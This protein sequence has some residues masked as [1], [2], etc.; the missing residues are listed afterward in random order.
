M[1]E[2]AHAYVTEP[3]SYSEARALADEL[4]VSA[5]LAVTLVRRGYR[6]VEDAR[7]FLEADEFHD[8]SQF[9]GMEDVVETLLAAAESRKRITVHGDYDVDGVCSTTILVSTLREL[10]ADCDWYI[11]DRL[12]EGYGV[13]VAGVRK[14]AERGTNLLLTADCGITSATEVREARAAGLE[15]I[16]T[17]HHAPS[18]DVPDCPVLHPVLSDY[19]FADLC[20][21]GVAYKLAC[22][23]RAAA[24]SGGGEADD[25]DLDLV[26][27][28]TVADVVPLVGENRC[29]VRRGLAVARR[30]ARPGMRALIEASGSDA[31]R[32][33]EGDL[34]FRLAP[35]IN[36]AGRL[37]RADAGVE[38]FLTEDS[39]RAAEIAVELDR[40]NRERRLAEREVEG[41]AEAARRELPTELQEGP[42]LVVAGQGWHPGVVGIVASRLV[43]RYWRPVILLSFDEAGSGRGS[44]RSIPGFD[45]LGGLQA[46]SEHLGRFGGHKAAAGLEIQRSELESFREAFIA[47]A[48]QA[49]GPEE[50]TRTERIDA[51]VGGDG[52]GMEL[53][54]ELEKLAP[55]GPGNPGVRLLVPSAR[56]GDVKSM[57]DGK[58]SRFS[59]QSAGAKAVGVAFGRPSLP[60]GDKEAVDAAIRLEVNQWNGAVEPR[61]V[62]NELYRLSDDVVGEPL[63]GCSC[64]EDEWWRRFEAELEAPLVADSEPEVSQARGE[65]QLVRAGSPIATMAELVSSGESVLA[66]CADASRRA[67]LAVGAAGLARF[68]GGAA[69]IAC[70]RCS[71]GAVSALA[72]RSEAG[73]ALSDFSA[74]LLL[75]DLVRGFDHVVLVD[76]PASEQESALAL[77]GPGGSYLHSAWGEQERGFALRV[78]DDEFGMRRPL[79]A[80]FRGLARAEGADGA[81]LRE[82]LSGNGE[83]RHGPELAARCVRVLNELELIIWDA[84][85]RERTLRVVSS[86]HTNLERSAAFRAYNARFEEGKKYLASLR[87]P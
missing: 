46:C 51:L 21:T 11:P 70:G 85:S 53:A 3:Y 38:L 48:G 78:L 35:R 10:G 34:A 84:D 66:L 43:E 50:L 8:P 19:P 77:L 44:G 23:L 15:V 87:Q 33:D 54:T 52:L 29:L 75:P 22:A 47:H 40:T 71:S 39:E 81:E 5:P 82:A 72:A 36:A 28:A 17:D 45:L 73:L 30:G 69:Q 62:L 32:L 13:S 56:L 12:G 1:A 67:E 6:T 18:E 60:V 7:R 65:R 61:V 14:L 20:G 41:A 74:L 16:V 49:L 55:F 79:R 86:E 64:D 27:L 25:A 80:V 76:P 42:A 31:E 58:H 68:A 24:G 57:G 9:A 4:D 59:L 2:P 83:H 26:A 63:H 37:Y